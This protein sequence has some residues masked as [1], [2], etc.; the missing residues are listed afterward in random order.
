[1]SFPQTKISPNSACL[2]APRENQFTQCSH[3]FASLPAPHY[4]S[5]LSPCINTIYKASKMAKSG[6]KSNL[7]TFHICLSDWSRSSYQRVCRFEQSAQTRHSVQLK[8]LFILLLPPLTI[9][10]LPVKT[11]YKL[12][13]ISSF[14]FSLCFLFVIINFLKT[15][16]FARSF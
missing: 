11:R 1:M 12:P 5:M 6:R 4:R 16:S 9:T 13:Q 3:Q 8:Q 2:V 10:I 7:P 15:F 14:I